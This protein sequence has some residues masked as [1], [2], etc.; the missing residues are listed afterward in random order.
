MSDLFPVTT[1]GEWRS[2]FFED[3]FK[4]GKTEEF[5]GVSGQIFSGRAMDSTPFSYFRHYFGLI[6]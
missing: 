3:I 4:N 1:T 5:E 2:T 6:S